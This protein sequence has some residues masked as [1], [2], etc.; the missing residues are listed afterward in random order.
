MIINDLS[1]SIP[2]YISVLLY[3]YFLFYRA[4]DPEERQEMRFLDVPL[5][6]NGLQPFVILQLA[7]LILG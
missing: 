6:L 1:T 4:D 5:E 3:P 7:A 2:A